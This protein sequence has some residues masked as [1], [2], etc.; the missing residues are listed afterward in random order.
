M[1]LGTRTSKNQTGNPRYKMAQ[2]FGGPAWSTTLCG[3]RDLGSA[4]SALTPGRN[5][6][7]KLLLNER[8]D[9]SSQQLDGP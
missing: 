8:R 4:P 7:V 1:Q 9:A 2:E 3:Q 6:G 5:Y